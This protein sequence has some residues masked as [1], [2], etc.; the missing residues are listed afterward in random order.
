MQHQDDGLRPPLIFT[1]F[2]SDIEESTDSITLTCLDSLGFLSNETL[3]NEN[4][5][6]KGDAA[7]IIKSVIAGSSYAPPI[8]RISTSLVTDAI[9]IETERQ[10][11][12]CSSP[13]CSRIH[14]CST[15]TDDDLR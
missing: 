4:I 14:Q 7:S 15:D 6:V 12:A 11:E 5:V 10:D 9:R 1:G 3:L 8:E 2:V 13:N